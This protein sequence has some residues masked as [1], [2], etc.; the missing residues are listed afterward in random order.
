MCLKFQCPPHNHDPKVH[1][2]QGQSPKSQSLILKRLPS[3][4][5]IQ[6]SQSPLPLSHDPKVRKGSLH[7]QIQLLIIKKTLLSHLLR[8]KSRGSLDLKSV[9]VS[10]STSRVWTEKILSPHHLGPRAGA[11]KF[12]SLQHHS[13][14][15]RIS[16]SPSL[17]LL[18]LVLHRYRIRALNPLPS[19]RT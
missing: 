16:R 13:P 6:I 10:R 14:Q 5:L 19:K 3:Q 2:V 9:S 17:K 4:L 11:E 8:L 1:I 15:A 7:F 12:L 18:L